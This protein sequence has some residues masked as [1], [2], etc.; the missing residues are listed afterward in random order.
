MGLFSNLILSLIHF[1]L[2]FIDVLFFFVVVRMLCYRRQCRWLNALDSAG[3]PLVDWL[4]GYIQK[5]VGHINHKIYSQKALLV[6][7]MLTL[8]FARFFLVALFS[9]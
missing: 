1:T 5:G 6:I 2:I 7:G 3:K 9:E 8:M 4:T